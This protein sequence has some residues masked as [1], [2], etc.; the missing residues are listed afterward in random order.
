M[1]KEV[2]KFKRKNALYMY[3]YK[4]CKNY[5]DCNLAYLFVW[6]E[7][8]CKIFHW[9]IRGQDTD[10]VQVLYKMF[11]GSIRGYITHPIWVQFDK[12]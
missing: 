8:A 10:I 1:R 2:L 6:F 7:C 3:V 9:A 5:I 11:Q 4:V 12:A